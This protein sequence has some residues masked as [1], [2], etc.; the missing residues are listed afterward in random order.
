MRYLLWSAPF[1]ALTML[2]WGTT[3][4]DDG[5]GGD[6][7]ADGDSDIDWVA[8]CGETGQSCDDSLQCPEYQVCVEHV[9]DCAYDRYYEIH[10]TS[11]AIHG[12]QANNDCWDGE[13]PVCEDPDPYVTV[14]IGDTAHTTKTKTDTTNP[15][16][17]ERFKAFIGHPDPDATGYWTTIYD[18]DPEGDDDL[19]LDFPGLTTGWP[20]Y[21]ETLRNAGVH[22]K[23]GSE[24]ARTVLEF[25]LAPLPDE[26]E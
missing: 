26:E 15:M 18:E 17:D 8:V 21:V 4:C 11:A 5:N 3:A 25:I 13:A 12:R 10:I 6:G 9:C 14:K 16:W 22:V 19:I 20:I 7:D 1:L 24:K 23:Q 2:V